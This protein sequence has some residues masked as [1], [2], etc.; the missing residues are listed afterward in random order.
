VLLNITNDLIAPTKGRSSVVPT[1]ITKQLQKQTSQHGL[2]TKEIIDSFANMGLI[3]SVLC[4]ENNDA[5][6]NEIEK[7]I[8]TAIRADIIII[9]WEI[10]SYKNGQIAIK[11][12]NQIIEKD[13]T[14]ERLRFICIYTGSN[15]LATD[16]SYIIQNE[17]FNN[18]VEEENFDKD[19]LMFRKNSLLIALVGKK[20]SGLPDK[21]KHLEI[22]EQNLPDKIISIFTKEYSGLIPNVAMNSISIIKKNSHKLLAKFNKN[23]DTPYL[24]HRATIPKQVDAE[25]HLIHFLS[26]EIN[27]LLLNDS[28]MIINNKIIQKWFYDQFPDDKEFD[29][30]DKKIQRESLLSCFH[31]GISNTELTLN[32]K[33][34]EKLYKTLTRLLANIDNDKLDLEFS[35]LSIFKTRYKSERPYLTTGTIIQNLRTKKYWIC[36]QPKCD[37]TRLSEPKSF[38]L[39]PLLKEFNPKS[40]VSMPNFEIKGDTTFWHIPTVPCYCNMIEFKSALNKTDLVYSRKQNSDWIFLTNNK[41]HFKYMVDLKDEFAQDILNKYASFHARVGTNP[42]EWLRKSTL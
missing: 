28:N 36:I 42:S 39:L 31:N 19:N 38:P 18:D 1:N 24:T 27:S 13:S 40:K 25:I 21:Y 32:K 20:G 9:D 34:K 30:E 29:F 11:I 16:I 23:L 33:Q 2:N 8:H 35:K 15:E 10:H 3:C 22:S 4:P 37:C 7:M 6:N 17:I 12:I 41:V 5:I 26:S 14:P